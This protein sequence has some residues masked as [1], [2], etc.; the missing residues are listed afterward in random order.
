MGD[1]AG[2]LAAAKASLVVAEK[3]TMPLLKDEYVRR[4]NE[5]IARL[6]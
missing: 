4:N 2:A 5:L 1:K 6:K 3:A